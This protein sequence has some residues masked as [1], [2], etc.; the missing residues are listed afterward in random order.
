VAPAFAAE[1]D[2]EDI[3]F[4]FSSGAGENNPGDISTAARAMNYD[5][6]ACG[7]RSAPKKREILQLFL[8]EDDEGDQRDRE[9]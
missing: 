2:G 8:D 9:S 7:F 4:S 5:L 3:L 1:F 6:L